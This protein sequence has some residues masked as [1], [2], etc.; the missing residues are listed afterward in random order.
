[1]FLAIYSIERQ[2][3]SGVVRGPVG[4]G[5]DIVGEETMNVNLQS[6]IG[7]IKTCSQFLDSIIISVSLYCK[8]LNAFSCCNTSLLLMFAAGSR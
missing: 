8:M 5:T 1:M 6:N 2:S 3:E 7:K 4:R